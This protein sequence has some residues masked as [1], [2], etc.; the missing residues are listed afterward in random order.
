MGRKIIFISLGTV[1][2]S[3]Y[4]AKPFGVHALADDVK[5]KEEGRRSLSE[6][7]GKEFCQQVRRTCFDALGGQ[8]AFLVIMTLGPMKDAPKGLPLAPANILVHIVVPWIE[9]LRLRDAFITHGGANGSSN[10]RGAHLRRPA[11]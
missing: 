3:I 10:G 6:Y 4:W 11:Q 9:V 5:S 2:T 8:D 7:T 1:A